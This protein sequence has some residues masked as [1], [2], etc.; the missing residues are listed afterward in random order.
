MRQSV[1]DYGAGGKKHNALTKGSSVRK[2]VTGSQSIIQNLITIFYCRHS[3]N[4][5]KN[6]YIIFRFPAVFDGKSMFGDSVYMKLSFLI[7][8]QR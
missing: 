6:V 7:M 3:A 8:Q 2:K 5:Y 4:V 1:E